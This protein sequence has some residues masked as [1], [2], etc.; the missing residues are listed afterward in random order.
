MS[1]VL[2]GAALAAWFV[3]PSGSV[4][5][6]L[7]FQLAWSNLIVAVF[8][9]LPGLPLD[10]GRAL[11]AIVWRITGNRHTGSTVAG[12]IGRGVAAAVFASGL[13]LAAFGNYNLVTV[14]FLVLVA[15]TMWQ[16]ATVAIAQGRLAARLPRLNLRQISRPVVTRCRPGPRWRRRS[17]D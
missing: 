3:L 11:R 16:G 10:G 7:A 4:V 13:A 2:G 9:S 8:N 1:A 6:H 17:D 14:A 5:N 12:W 15:M